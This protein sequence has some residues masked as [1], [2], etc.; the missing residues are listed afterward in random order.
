MI[1]PVLRPVGDRAVLAEFDGLEAVLATFAEL[2]RMRDANANGIRAASGA[3]ALDLAASDSRSL[4]ADRVA[5]A[6][7]S[8]STPAGIDDLVPAARTIL[9]RFDPA[10]TTARRIGALVT[11]A[12]GR[13]RQPQSGSAH[14]LEHDGLAGRA[15]RR[16]PTSTN[17]DP[18]VIE[19]VYDGPDLDDVARQLGVP[20]DE[21]VRRHTNAHYTAAFTGFAPGFAYLTAPDADLDVPRRE[22][23]RTR[24]P[25]GSV[26]LADEWSGVYPTASPG[27]WQLIG[28]T[29]AVLWRLDRTPPAL[30][31]PGDAVRFA[32]VREHARARATSTAA[33]GSTSP[34]PGVAA[35]AGASAAPTGPTRSAEH[36]NA[37][38]APMT[39]AADGVP[40]FTIERTTF[41]LL[42]EDSGRPRAASL[43]LGRSGALDRA[44]ARRANDL[45]GNPTEEP[46]LEL[47]LADAELLARQDAVLALT[48]APASIAVESADGVEREAEPD[49]PFLVRAGERV[50]LSP[51]AHGMRSYLALRGGIAAEAPIGS[52]SRDTLTGIGPAP[53]GTGAAIRVKPLREGVRSTARVDAAQHDHESHDA[54]DEIDRSDAGARAD[55]GPGAPAHADTGPARVRVV[56][57][58]RDDEF[59]EEAVDA[60]LRTAWTV[61]ERSDRVGLRLVDGPTIARR[62]GATAFASE[63]TLPGSI[64]VPANGEPVVFLADAPVTGGYPV[65]ATVVDADLDALG[66]LRPGERL[67]FERV[68]PE[69]TATDDERTE[70]ASERAY[71]EPD[72]PHRRIGVVTVTTPDG[73]T[74]ALMT[75]DLSAGARGRSIV[76]VLGA[77]GLTEVTA[78]RLAQL[79]RSAPAAPG[80][81]AVHEFAV[82][83]PEREPE[84]GSRTSSRAGYGQDGQEHDDCERTGREPAVS[85]LGVRDAAPVDGAMLEASL[86]IELADLPRRLDEAMSLAPHAP[87]ALACTIALEA[88]DHGFAAAPASVEPAAF[89]VTAM[90]PGG[91]CVRVVAHAAS[92]GRPEV[93]SVVVSPSIVPV[94][95]PAQDPA[96]TPPRALTTRP[97]GREEDA[98]LLARARRAAREIE[99]EGGAST[100]RLIQRIL[101]DHGAD[102]L[103]GRLLAELLERRLAVDA[104][105]RDAVRDDGLVRGSVELDGRRVPFS[106]G[107]A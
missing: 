103:A 99:V 23:P 33:T 21:V 38:E 11:R 60:F 80:R 77:G 71:P 56:L 50:L 87:R 39:G 6:R 46:V 30:I 47:V 57:G 105:F 48:G 27:G 88:V 25:A 76:R 8:A 9:V 3:A 102:L 63:G 68:E 83:M 16:A 79:A 73:R 31:R 69:S 67:R 2:E 40:A 54:T 93:A 10:V 91:P 22:S 82:S 92:G 51:P 64:Q 58:P 90:L 70:A 37:A 28:S 66:R 75:L 106:V 53:L 26:G 72:G 41:P 55:D 78:A 95:R 62:D 86:G 19:V 36:G 61:S 104:A 59:A 107:P 100:A 84:P 52:A 35:R 14:I 49:R 65:I 45:V 12:H 13:A 7:H 5:D 96:E 24:V 97:H 74:E 17:A 101:D 29:D 20:R 89:P 43:G 94:R 15:H 98:E 4:D 18:V 42:I 1:A 85:P 34:A 44:A 32:A 81:V